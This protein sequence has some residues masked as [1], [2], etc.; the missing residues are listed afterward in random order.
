MLSEFRTRLLEHNAEHLLFD[1]L[2]AACRAHGLLKVHGRQR[3]DST[4][5]LA[6]VRALNRLELVTETM[7][8]ALNVLATVVPDWIRVHSQPE[9]V[10]RYERRPEHD[11]LPTTKDRQ[12]HLAE[13]IGADGRALLGAIYFG[14]APPWL[15]Q[16]AAVEILRRVW[17]QNYLQTD[18]TLTWRGADDIP[19]AAQFVSSPYDLDAHLAKKGSTC[20]VGY[21]IHLTETCEDDTPPLITHVATTAA[22]IA[23]GDVTPLI[24]QTLKEQDRLPATHIVDTGY[25]DAELLVTSRRDYGVD[26]LGPTRPDVKWQARAGEG[27]DVQHFQIDWEQQQATCPEGR[28]SISWTPAIDQR[29]NAVIKIK[30]STKDCGPCPS[31]AKCLRSR[32]RSPRRTVTVREHDQYVA[33]QA[34]RQRAQTPE[35]TAEYARRAGIEGTLSR[36]V[37]T[38]GLRRARYSGAAKVHLEHLLIATAMNFLRVSEWIGETPRAKTRRSA[39][40]RLMKPFARE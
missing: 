36:G 33:L 19:P 11:R 38:C 30:F 10:K 23:D 40:I 26:L 6:A 37:R 24:H 31:R 17:V 9:W 29:T 4:H 2:L 28:T 3:S 15:R 1:T 34:A 12:Q 13:T 20:W 8:H 7:R 22:P 27:F 14:S 25:L 21:K 39:Y 32:K 5:V 18:E 35:Y 16:V